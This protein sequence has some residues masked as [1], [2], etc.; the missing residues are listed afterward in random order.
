LGNRQQEL[1]MKVFQFTDPTAFLIA[2]QSVTGLKHLLTAAQ[3]D[4][5]CIN[6]KHFFISSGRSQKITLKRLGGA[7]YLGIVIGYTNLEGSRIARLIP[8]VTVNKRKVIDVKK[9][10]PSM[11]TDVLRPASLAL[12]LSLGENGIRRLNIEAK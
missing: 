3:I 5:A 9:H 8:I 11:L 4:P 7:R 12:K 10:S 1:L 6:D 2:T